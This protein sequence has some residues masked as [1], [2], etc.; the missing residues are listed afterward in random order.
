LPFMA[1]GCLKVRRQERRGN[2]KGVKALG[3]W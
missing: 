3:L 2:G 1:S